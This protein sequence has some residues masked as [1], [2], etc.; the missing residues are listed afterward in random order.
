[1]AESRDH[2]E[3]TLVATMVL[4]MGLNVL[5]GTRVLMISMRMPVA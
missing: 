3:K 1:M 2:A 5:I 4:R